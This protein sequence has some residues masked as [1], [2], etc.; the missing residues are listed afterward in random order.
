MRV[1]EM[2]HVARGL[3]LLGAGTAQNTDPPRFGLERPWRLLAK[4]L[5][6]GS[7][8]CPGPRLIPRGRRL[9]CRAQVAMS[10][11]SPFF[12]GLAPDFRLQAADLRLQLGS[13]LLSASRLRQAVQDRRGGEAHGQSRP[14]EHLGR[15][16][17]HL[18]KLLEGYKS[19]S[20][21]SLVPSQRAFPSSG[22]GRQRRLP[23][24][25]V[26]WNGGALLPGLLALL[27][28][29]RRLVSGNGRAASHRL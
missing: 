21:D 25:G 29:L 26:F 7:A 6:S 19:S 28:S 18:S 5:L 23:E 1:V 10:L 16:W 17:L 12:D 4:P 8:A 27:E 24:V 15:L 22:I 13:A 2:L 3:R 9:L 11:W 14:L 20:T